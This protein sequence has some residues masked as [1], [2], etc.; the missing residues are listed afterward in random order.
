MNRIRPALTAEFV[1]TGLLLV[2]VV[3]SGIAVE[4]LGT[5]PAASLFIHAVTVGLGLAALIAALGPV[6]GAHFNPAVTIGF[7]LRRQVDRRTAGFYVLVQSLGAVVGTG[8]AHLSFGEPLATFAET[9]RTGPGLWL[10]ELIATAVLVGLILMLVGLGQEAR[11]PAAVGAWV[12]AAIVATA[13]TGFANPA[14][15]LARTVTDSYTGINPASVPMFL[16]AQLAGAFVAVAFV[17]STVDPKGVR[18]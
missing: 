12:A 2:L 15:T 11:V 5:D 16:I 8:V 3:G 10:S 18:V 4:R 14:V 7:L 13:S 1:G 17:R 9:V 6:S